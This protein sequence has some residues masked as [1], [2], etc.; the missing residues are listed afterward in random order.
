MAKK[1]NVS[2]NALEKYCK[3]VAPEAVEKTVTV[4]DDASITFT[5]K[6]RLSLD[7]SV[8]FIEDVVSEYINTQDLM[9]VPIAKEFIIGQNL[10]TYYAN[11][12]MPNNTEKAYDLVM[13]SFNIM[14]TILGSI[15]QNQYGILLRAIEERIRFEQHK[16]L[17]LQ[18]ARINQA[19]TEIEQFT[20]RMSTLF[21]GVDGSQMSEFISG[22]ADMAKRQDVTPQDIAN[23]IA[24]RTST[25][26][27]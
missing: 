17:T 8:R 7:E 10:L 25:T 16:M 19:V 20:S 24:N 11:F 22:M 4:G 23:A 18:E 1:N 14:N 6:P 27:D 2:I 5:V 15:D 26:E 21:D 13:G 3:A 12:T 9:I